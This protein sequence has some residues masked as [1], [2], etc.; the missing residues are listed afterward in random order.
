MPSVFDDP[1]GYMRDF[2]S[3]IA[4]M[5][6]KAS[7]LN[8]AMEAAQATAKSPGGE[9]RVTV[10]LGG[11]LQEIKLSSQAQ[12]L[13]PRTLAALIKE[14]YDEAAIQAG[15]ASTQALASV[16]GE[17]SEI[18]RQAKASRPPED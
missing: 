5:V 13:T 18:V 2:Q 14:T 11:T 3:R 15:N 16:F 17:D 12:T 4:T 7:S 8:E 1:E 6:D 10:G 9:V